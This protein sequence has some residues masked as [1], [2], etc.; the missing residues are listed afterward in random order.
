MGPAVHESSGELR[1]GLTATAAAAVL[2]GAVVVFGL[3]PASPF[4]LGRADEPTAPVVH[5]PHDRAVS[6][7]ALRLPQ[8]LPGPERRLSQ[9][10]PQRGGVRN[11]DNAAGGPQRP[12]PP[13]TPPS[14]PGSTS[15]PASAPRAPTE[16]SVPQP[17]QT[18]LLPPVLPPV[19]PVITVPPVSVPPVETL[20]PPL[21]PLELP[22]PPSIPELP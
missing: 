7:P 1:L 14:S 16:K 17:V 13:S 9:P 4:G 21:P 22:P 5:V 8:V 19:V 2:Y 6:G 20:L 10:E 3:G 11:S 15:A 12:E 18:E